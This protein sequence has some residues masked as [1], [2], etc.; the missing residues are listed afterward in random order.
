[1]EED[2]LHPSLIKW[3]QWRQEEEDLVLKTNYTLSFK[4]Q[5]KVLL[6]IYLALSLIAHTITTKT[7]INTKVEAKL[8]LQ[9]SLKGDLPIKEWLKLK[10]AVKWKLI[11]SLRLWFKED[12]K[13]LWNSW[14]W[15]PQRQPQQKKSTSKSKRSH[16]LKTICLKE[17]MTIKDPF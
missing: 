10:L 15:L 7:I 8:H 16:W 13:Q 6:L 5:E 17:E 3:V 14:T 12:G 11:L 1:M 2:L 9:L 4:I